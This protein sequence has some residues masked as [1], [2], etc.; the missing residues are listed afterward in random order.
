MSRSPEGGGRGAGV[1]EGAA[2]ESAVVGADAGGDAGVGRVDRDGVGGAARVLGVGDHLG[3]LEGF[4]G[5]VGDGG[6]DEAGG[7]ADH[8][9]HLLGGYV[10]GGDDEVGFVLARG[11]VED[12]E[13]LAS[14]WL[15][16]AFGWSER[17]ETVA[18]TEGVNAGGDGVKLTLVYCVG[19][20]DVGLEAGGYW[21]SGSVRRRGS[22]SLAGNFF[23]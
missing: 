11:V 6:A 19:R 7:V 21:K 13:E 5:G 10:L 8:E 15:E 14:A 17:R 4:G 12:D 9:A 2:G 23:W 3:Q 20:H 1:G 22:C 16:S 18:R